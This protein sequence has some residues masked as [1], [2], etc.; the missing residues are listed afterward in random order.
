MTTT[1]AEKSTARS[2]LRLQHIQ[3][4]DNVKDLILLLYISMRVGFVV[5]LDLSIETFG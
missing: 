2:F 3:V 4:E 5:Q 1:R